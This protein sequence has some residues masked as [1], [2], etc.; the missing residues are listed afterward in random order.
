MEARRVLVMLHGWMDVSASFQ[1][2]ADALG[3]GWAI[4]APDWRGYGL[5]DRSGGDSYWFPDYLADLD[6]IL[7]HLSPGP[8]LLVGHSMGGNVALLYAGIRPERVRAVV[9]LEGFGLRETHAAQAPGRYAQWLDE[10]RAGAT[11]R[12]Y[13]DA[14]E[15]AA[16]LMRNNRRLRPDRAAFLARHWAQPRTDGRWEVAGDPAHRIVNPTLYRLDEVLACWERIACPVLWVRAASTEVLRFV[17]ESSDA[18]LEE[19]ER[20]REFIADCEPLVIEDAGHMVHHDQPE[21]VAQAIAD[22]VGRRVDVPGR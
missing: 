1:F 12:D 5:T 11:L 16:R 3:E 14:D 7:D 2:V 17:A 8:A 6:R 10:L 4:V 15:V 18:A 19:V 22:F 9:N 21:A 13:A 20:R